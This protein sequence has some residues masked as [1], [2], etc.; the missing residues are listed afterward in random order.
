[1][2][3]EKLGCPNS[4][5]ITFR[6]MSFVR[7]DGFYFRK[8]DGRKVQR[9]HCK[10]CG[11][12]FSHSSFEFEYQ[13][14]KRRINFPIYKLLCSGVSQRRIAKI[15][16]V[17]KNTIPRRLIYWAHKARFLNKKELERLKE[18]Y[19]QG[20]DEVQIDDLIT[21]ENSKLKPLTVSGAITSTRQILKLEV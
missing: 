1:M 12:K 11:K 14:K 5:C 9:F 4:K 3:K 16:G 6:E 18:T 19:S 10:N 21:K 8:N 17:N 2:L 7:K 20:L 13:Q 15:L